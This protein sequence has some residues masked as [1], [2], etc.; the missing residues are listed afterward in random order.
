MNEN[1]RQL[2]ESP[3]SRLAAILDSHQPRNLLA[4]SQNPVPVLEQWSEDH[5]CSLTTI[6]DNDPLSRM[7][8][9]GRFDMAVVADQ[10]EYMNHHLGEELLGRLRNLHTESL[11]VVYQPQLAPARL[12]WHHNEFLGMGMR[13]DRTFVNDEGREMVLYTYELATYNFVR[14][15]NNPQFWANPEN[16]GKYWW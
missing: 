6:M 1:A 3:Q 13:R 11:V 8:E 12:R 4:V 16:W 15:W 9:L 10:L 5:D 14:K 2:S 7:R